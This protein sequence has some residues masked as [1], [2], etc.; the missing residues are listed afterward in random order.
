M[1]RVY[2]EGGTGSE[3]ETEMEDEHRKKV[4][5][6]ER[7]DNQRVNLERQKDRKEERESAAGPRR[8]VAVTAAEQKSPTGHYG[9]VLQMSAKSGPP[10]EASRTPWDLQESR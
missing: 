5:E 3:N 9:P 1:K 4:T 10:R 8:T 7:C 2:W 6:R